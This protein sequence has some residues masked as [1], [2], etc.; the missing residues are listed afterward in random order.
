[1]P[2]EGKDLI[3]HHRGYNKTQEGMTIPATSPRQARFFRWA[4]HNPAQA[5]SEGKAQG[6]SHQQ[7][8]EFASTP[9]S[10][11][12]HHRPTFAANGQLPMEHVVNAGIGGKVFPS[13]GALDGVPLQMGLRK[14]KPYGA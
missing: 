8:H 11:I 6:L 5:K 13:K 1:M 2:G 3:N 14:R 12:P 9:D 7:M 10:A 4:E